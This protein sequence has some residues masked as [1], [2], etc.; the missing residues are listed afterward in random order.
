M[1]VFSFSSFFLSC[2]FDSKESPEKKPYIQEKNAVNFE[3]W[4]IR[5]AYDNRDNIS[6]LVI[7]EMY[8][9]SL[10]SIG[11]C[12]KLEIIIFRQIQTLDIKYTITHLSKLP[13]LKELYFIDC[14]FQYLPDEIT[15]LKE[16]QVLEI[17]PQK[18]KS[19]SPEFFNLKSLKKIKFTTDLFSD[20]FVRF[21][22]LKV[23]NVISENEDNYWP[24][25]TQLSTLEELYLPTKITHIPKELQNLNKL[26]KIDISG[27]LYEKKITNQVRS[28]PKSLIDEL[29]KLKSILPVNC[30]IIMSGNNKY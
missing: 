19:I 15:T 23:L 1:L 28:N 16:L 13:Q 25:V 14:N 20:D 27:S 7:D 29:N 8:Q 30:V 4:S 12:K 3:A 6:Y 2:N 17:S 24:V 26:R 21:D 5:N 9:G 18:I 10:D 22:S 11:A